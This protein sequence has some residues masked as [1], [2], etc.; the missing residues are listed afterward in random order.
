MYNVYICGRDGVSTEKIGAARWK[1]S[2]KWHGGA[3]DGKTDN[4]LRNSTTGKWGK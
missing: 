4:N 3:S 2:E 1:R